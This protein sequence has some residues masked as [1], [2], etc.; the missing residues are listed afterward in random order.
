M[1]G[2]KKNF[3]TRYFPDIYLATGGI[4][5]GNQIIKRFETYKL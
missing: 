1:K 4:C 2:N 5:Y 3:Y